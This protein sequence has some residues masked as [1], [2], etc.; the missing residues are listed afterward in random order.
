M[1]WASA[2][3]FMDIPLDIKLKERIMPTNLVDN[4][5]T[6]NEKELTTVA[7]TSS[8]CHQLIAILHSHTLGSQPIA[9]TTLDNLGTHQVTIVLVQSS[10]PLALQSSK[11]F[12]LHDFFNSI[13]SESVS[14]LESSNSSSV[15]LSSIL[16]NLGSFCVFI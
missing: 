2:T 11:L 9:R 16:S 15:F 14:T 7:L 6:D 8:Q 5:T 4:P 3:K 1:C 12:A 13:G 10:K